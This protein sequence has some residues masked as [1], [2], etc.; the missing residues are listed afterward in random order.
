MMNKLCANMRDI[1]YI[2][3]RSSKCRLYNK[4]GQNTVIVHIGAIITDLLPFHQSNDRAASSQARLAETKAST[5]AVLKDNPHRE[6]PSTVWWHSEDNRYQK[7]WAL[8]IS[9]HPGDD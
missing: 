4:H 3:Y 5:S 2:C 9:F 7:P 8:Q 6:D 1:S